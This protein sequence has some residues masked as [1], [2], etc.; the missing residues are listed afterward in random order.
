MKR[1]RRAQGRRVLTILAAVSALFYLTMF[2]GPV[3]L[4]PSN[5]GRGALHCQ[6]LY[7]PGVDEPYAY[8]CERTR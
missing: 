7:M 8:T 4:G 1:V 2:T 3:D 5:G 6:D